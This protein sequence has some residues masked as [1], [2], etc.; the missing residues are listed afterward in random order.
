MPTDDKTFDLPRRRRGFLPWGTAL[1]LGV[2]MLALIAVGILSMRSVRNDAETGDR[3]THAM[4]VLE[5]VETLLSRIKDAET[6]QRGYLLTGRET[7]L[8]PFTNAKNDLGG[9]VAQLKALV[10]ESPDQ[11]ARLAKLDN[12][13]NQKMAELDDTVELRRAGRGE[14]A[15]ARVQTDRGKLLMDQIRTQVNQMTNAE[16]TSLFQ[17]QTEWKNSAAD[18]A[19]VVIV[20]LSA[21]L[22]LLFW[23][24]KPLPA[25]GRTMVHP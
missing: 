8:E 10:A 17:R 14:D 19:Q 23:F 15:L 9:V 6:G 25:V 22:I 11:T 20:G 12:Y 4:A 24:W 18:T 5:N 13:I 21:V 1:G 16:R 2:A 3:V 7:Y